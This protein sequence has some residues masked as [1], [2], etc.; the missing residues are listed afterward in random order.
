M[1]PYLPKIARQMAR[2]ATLRSTFKNFCTAKA[3]SIFKLETNVTTE[4]LETLQLLF[5]EFF[6]VARRC[7]FHFSNL[8]NN[9]EN[10][11]LLK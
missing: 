6:S 3:V 10:K 7:T 4:R 8:A 5:L 11:T 1:I 2:I 9:G